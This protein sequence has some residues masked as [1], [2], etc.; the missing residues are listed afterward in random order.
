MTLEQVFFASQSV[1]GVG[2]VCSLIFVG[3]QVRGST[4]AVRAATEQAIQENFAGIYVSLQ[5]SRSALAGITKGVVD[6]GALSSFRRLVIQ[7]GFATSLL[8]YLAHGE[9][10]ASGGRTRPREICPRRV[11]SEGTKTRRSGAHPGRLLAQRA[12][13]EVF[14]GTDRHP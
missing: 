4:K 13:I 5:A 1:A 12:V 9:A 2:V 3:L 7:L 6:Y 11:L 14:D 10:A 8:I